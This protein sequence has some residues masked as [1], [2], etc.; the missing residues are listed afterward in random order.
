METTNE[1]EGKLGLRIAVCWRPIPA[2]AGE[3]HFI[4]GFLRRQ[5]HC[6]I[7]TPDA[8]LDLSTLDVVLVLENHG[9]FPAIMREF[10]AAR[11]K[12]T[13]LPLMVVWH[14]EPLPLPRNA[15]VPA[16]RL[17]AREIAKVLLRDSRATDVFT[18]LR[19]LQRLTMEQ[20]PVLLAVSSHGWQES[21]AERGIV[22]SCVPY[23]YEVGDGMGEETLDGPQDIEALFLGS[24]VP[25]RRRIIKRLRS[26]GIKVEA[27]GSWFEK[28]L[29][30]QS[31][32]RL[33]NGAQTFLNIQRYPREI[34]AHRLLLGMANRSLVVSEP[35][36]NPAPFQPG[37]H[38]VES[39]AYGMPEVIR[40]YRAHPAER[41]E[42][43]DRAYRFVTQELRME[44]SVLRMLSLIDQ[45]RSSLKVSS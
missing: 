7:Q 13:L 30:G 23:G 39:E 21:L 36:Y 25:R 35:I 37:R 31:R 16:S 28:Q 6:A 3:E 20:W 27:R 24:M 34:G 43:V 4:T 18:N 26:L 17:N 1:I 42:I 8:S 9:W 33:I 10:R 45:K 5:G 2:R 11:K 14:W 19:N 22:A 40:Y 38:F 15:G 29:W 41:L 32:A 44:T 12:G